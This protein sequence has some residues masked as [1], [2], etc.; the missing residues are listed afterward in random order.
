[1]APKKKADQ[2]AEEAARKEAEEA[3]A[4]AAEEAAAR[5]AAEAEAARI[6]AEEAAA[7]AAL[8]A[9]A[10]VIPDLLVRVRQGTP[11]DC[12]KALQVLCERCSDDV[13]AQ[14]KV[15][16][17][18]GIAALIETIVEGLPGQKEWA[19]R[20]LVAATSSCVQG[21]DAVLKLKG[22]GAIVLLAG[23]TWAT[24]VHKELAARV[25]QNLVADD[26]LKLQNAIV[27]ENGLVP[28]ARLASR[29][30]STGQQLAARWT[31][32]RIAK[33]DK[34]NLMKVQDALGVELLVDMILR[35]ESDVR[36]MAVQMLGTYESGTSE[37]LR[38][39]RTG[40]N[41]QPE[42]ALKAIVDLCS[43]RL[44]QTVQLLLGS[45]GGVE[46]LLH[47]IANGTTSIKQCAPVTLGSMVNGNHG[48]QTLFGE[49]GGV[50]CLMEMISTG[51]AAQKEAA[52]RSI[53]HLVAGHSANQR[54]LIA[55]EGVELLLNQAKFGHRGEK[56]A[57]I[58]AISKLVAGSFEA[59]S[60][61]AARGAI[62]KLCLMANSGAPSIKEA[63]ANALAELCAGHAENKR[64]VAAEG[65]IG[66]LLGLVERGTPGQQFAAA[67]TLGVLAYRDGDMQARLA[68]QSGVSKLLH[69]HR[70]G[71]PEQ[72][73]AASLAML[74]ASGGSPL[75]DSP[76]DAS[77]LTKRT[78][79]RVERGLRRTGSAVLLGK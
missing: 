40:A 53:G 75:P 48:N 23:A 67:S 38:L 9:E 17:N 33:G 49:A 31:L 6:A 5:Q 46:V 7:Q 8:E 55:S 52:S 63:A 39:A 1:M 19:A 45:I 24:G 35:G 29:D 70:C 47:L 12:N 51:N 79:I 14:Q 59:Q 78:P 76:V 74:R 15:A 69:L 42:V 13:E 72:R 61:V 2:E 16:A 77:G 50:S 44:K 3:A 58:F 20:A 36:S 43:G 26:H 18:G 66:C 32:C 54:E 57:A 21:R 60:E 56:E 22:V 30:A 71:G 37:L 10:R 64:S 73:R 25:L 27:A 4:R 62:P 41:G 28:L 65:S 68:E 11:V 34:D